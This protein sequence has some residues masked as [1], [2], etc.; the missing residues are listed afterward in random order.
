MLRRLV[1]EP[2]ALPAV[3][4]EA[5]DLCHF[6]AASGDDRHRATGMDED[7]EA[8]CYNC[9][10]SY[11]NQRDHRLLERHRIRDW[12]LCCRDAA[13][14]PSPSGDPRAVH[15]ARLLNLCGS[16]LE[17]RW[18]RFLDA[19][20]LSLPSAAQRFVEAC[21]TRPDFAY[22]EAHAVIYVDGPPHDY[23]ERQSRDSEQT[24]CLEDHGW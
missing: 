15:L 24:N 20:G 21:Q 7:C 10:M 22:E 3:A 5:L 12:L 23:P 1:E 19:R 9:L 11:S 13:V 14:E 6:D 4:R 18:I 2:A 8:A 16:E 17:Q